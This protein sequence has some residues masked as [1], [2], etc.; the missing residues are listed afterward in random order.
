MHLSKEQLE[1]QEQHLLGRASI[2]IETHCKLFHSE[3][4]SR[5]FS[6]NHH[7]LFEVI[8]DPSQ[9]FILVM[10]HRGFGKTSIFNFA[11]PSQ[12][13]TFNKA[14][15]VV[16]VSSG[17]MHATT[18]SEN[19]KRELLTNPATQSVIGD[20]RSDTFT[21]DA[22]TTTNGVTVFPRGSGQQ[23]R[24]TLFGNDRPD[25]I[26]VDD[27]EDS[28]S[29]LSDEQRA[30]LKEWF[31][32][33]LT[34]SVDRSKDDWRVIVVGTLLHENALLQDLRD[35]SSWTHVDLPLA[36]SEEGVYKS[37]W[38][39]FMSDE[40]V[41]DEMATYRRRGMI[42]AWYRENMNIANPR[43]DAVFRPEHFQY[44]DEEAEKL[45]EKVDVDNIILVDPTKSEKAHSAHSAIVGVAIDY[46]KN[47]IYV[48]DVVNEKITTDKLYDEVFAMAARLNASTIGIEVTGLNEFITQPFKNEML[49]R[50]LNY[51][52]IELKARQGKGEYSGRTKGKAGRVAALA[53]YYRMGS[54]K[55]NRSATY[56]LEEQLLGFPRPKAWDIMDALGYVVEMLHLGDRYFE[57]PDLDTGETGYAGSS[58][59]MEK[60]YERLLLEDEEGALDP[61][62]SAL[63][64][65][66]FS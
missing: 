25:L 46:T 41:Q 4:F 11:V 26:V 64:M 30:K 12:A 56:E 45:S 65:A 21:K 29:V 38:P 51:E 1:R 24:G 3:R 34:Y 62:M 32:S 63:E 9:K 66:C 22:W 6:R 52:F 58:E 16:P 53:P 8:D 13:I 10:A 48:R 28:E 27:L 59:A 40:K 55:H 43:E 2:S 14:K 20:I 36:Y 42:D 61:E 23:V 35:D 5:P 47:L 44:Y 37:Y 54:M 33:D 57:T 49:R 39:T 15:V 17:A 19:L 7:E 60:E 50:G 18:Q 31:F